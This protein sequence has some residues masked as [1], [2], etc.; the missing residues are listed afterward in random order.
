MLP[1]NTTAFL[2]PQDAGVIQAFKSKITALRAQHLVDKFDALLETADESNKENF[3]SLVNKLH[4]VSLLQA[5]GWAK[6]A[7]HCVSR[8]TIINCWRHTG[9]IDEDI[10]ELIDSMRNM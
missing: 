5:L 2:Q 10:Y 9:I 3:A 6:E 8:D 4:E 7:W 1:P